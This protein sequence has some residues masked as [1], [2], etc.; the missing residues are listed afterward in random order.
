MKNIVLIGLP[1]AGKST[2]G[3]IL[4]KTLG[5]KFIDTDIVIQENIGKFLQTI[6]NEDGTE[7]FLKI[8]EKNILGLNETNTVIATG[9][10]VVYSTHAMEHLKSDGIL[11]YLNISFD[12]MSKRLRNIKNRGV[13]MIPGQSLYDM[14]NQR[15]PLYEKYADITIDCSFG[16]FENVV[17]KVVEKIQ[18]IR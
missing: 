5:M 10:S 6:I 13:V 17:G 1:G 15:I 4:A 2:I 9:G 3:V 7:A 8:E 12:E 18:K 11:V 16:D 14:V